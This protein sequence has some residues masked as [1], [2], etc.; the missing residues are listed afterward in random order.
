MKCCLYFVEKHSGESMVTLLTSDISLQQGGGNSS[1]VANLG[2]RT[3][4]YA[5]EICKNRGVRVEP[6]LDF[7]KRY[8]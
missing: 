3:S 7:Y 2:T 5:L 4:P 6:V 8:V 1:K